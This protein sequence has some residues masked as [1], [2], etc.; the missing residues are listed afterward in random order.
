VNTPRHDLTFSEAVY[1]A[2]HPDRGARTGGA[3]VLVE[4]APSTVVARLEDLLELRDRARVRG[5]RALE[6][7]YTERLIDEVWDDSFGLNGP[8][9]HAA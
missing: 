6:T 8:G 9:G 4:V 3:G 1:S 5:Y 7:A 2:N